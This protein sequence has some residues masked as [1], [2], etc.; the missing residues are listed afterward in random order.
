[1][2]D[3]KTCVL[4]FALQLFDDSPHFV[5]TKILVLESQLDVIRHESLAINLAAL[6][7][8]KRCEG[9]IIR[10]HFGHL[11]AIAIPDVKGVGQGLGKGYLG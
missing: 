7:Q 4:A 6:F 5:P 10:P 3:I 2:A 11:Q 8:L 9:E 1:L